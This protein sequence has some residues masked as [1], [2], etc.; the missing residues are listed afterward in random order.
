MPT[1]P[2]PQRATCP[3]CHTTART[4]QTGRWYNHNNPDGTRCPNSRQHVDGWN[5]PKPQSPRPRPRAKNAGHP[6][7]EIEGIWHRRMRVYDLRL[8]GVDYPTIAVSLTR[9]AAAD[10]ANARIGAQDR[11]WQTRFGYDATHGIEANCGLAQQD[12]KHARTLR[13]AKEE[14]VVDDARSATV[15]QHRRL[16]MAFLPR[17]VA[18]N[19]QAGAEVRQNLRAISALLGLDAPQAVRIDWTPDDPEI[20]GVVDQVMGLIASLSAPAEEH[21]VIDHEVLP[22]GLDGPV[23][24]D[25]GVA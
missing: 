9:Q 10:P 2:A 20:R 4:S 8:S 5:P 7:I 25:G 18:G 15:E 12:Y 3:T 23:G 16:I 6:E 22:A 13:H 14:E 21:P 1:R 24:P 11:V 17:A 19:V